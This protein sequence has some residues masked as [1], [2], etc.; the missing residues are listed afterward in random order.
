MLHIIMRA[1]LFLSFLTCVMN[2]QNHITPAEISALNATLNGLGCRTSMSCQALYTNLTSSN[3]SCTA[4]KHASCD[5]SSLSYL[6]LSSLALS[7]I[8][9]ADIGNLTNLVYLHLSDNNLSSTLP[10]EFFS[11]TSLA[12]LYLSSNLL[13]GTISS[14]IGLLSRLTELG[15]DYCNFTGS[16]PSELGVLSG[17]EKLY[18]WETLALN[19]TIPS[20]LSMLINLQCESCIIGPYSTVTNCPPHCFCSQAAVGCTTTST[21]VTTTSTIRLS[22]S[23]SSSTALTNASLTGVSESTASVSLDSHTPTASVSFDSHTPAASPTLASSTSL[24]GPV[25]GGVVAGL[26]VLLLVLVALLYF[27]RRKSRSASQSAGTSVSSLTGAHEYGKIT[28]AQYGETTLTD[29]EA[30]YKQ[31]SLAADI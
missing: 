29:V 1:V 8:V 6:E 19:G 18:I 16:L 12:E 31:S 2:A 23:M 20:S 22:S 30:T 3:W 24:V 4:S 17:L 21:I 26:V 14:Q 28:V 25:I 27:W 10:R 15:L 13:S 7:G 11:L 9:P 5:N